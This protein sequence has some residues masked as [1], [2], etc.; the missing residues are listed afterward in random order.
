M[1]LFLKINLKNKM[2]KKLYSKENGTNKITDGSLFATT[3]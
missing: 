2:R 1:C 3:I